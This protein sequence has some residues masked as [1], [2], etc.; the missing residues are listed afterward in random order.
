M[1]MRNPISAACV[2]GLVM[3]ASIRTQPAIA[4]S[5]DD[6]SAGV[7]Q[8]INS[9][10]DGFNRHDAHAVAAL[11]SDDG[12]FTNALQITTHGQ[13][14]IDEHLGPVFATRLK[15]AR[16]TYTLRNIR[17]LT[18]TIA[19][20]TTDYQLE[21][22]TDPSVTATPPHKGLLTWVV[23][24]SQRKWMI[25]SLEEAEIPTPCAPTVPPTKN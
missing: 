24:K 3:F 25:E 20:A 11:F 9:Y 2:L 12:D 10:M 19:L 13:K 21:G 7:Q 22:L 18:P 8:L 5:S 16:R 14:E 6:D 23:R 4:K 15:N 17:F 1:S